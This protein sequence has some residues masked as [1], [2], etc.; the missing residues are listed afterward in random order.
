[1]LTASSD[2]KGKAIVLASTYTER[3]LATAMPDTPGQRRHPQNA[4]KRD[5]GS[6]LPVRLKKR[7]ENADEWN[8]IVLRLLHKAS[9]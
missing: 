3:Q 4:R 2:Q 6:R 9:E 5:D 1:V 7:A 8:R